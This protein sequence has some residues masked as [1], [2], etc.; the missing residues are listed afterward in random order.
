MLWALW[1]AARG[2]PR[3]DTLVIFIL[4]TLVM[5]SAGCVINDFADR[6]F[7][8]RVERTRLRPLVTGA[9][10]VRAALILF[11]SLLALALG[12]VLLTNRL[13]LWMACA[14]ALLAA[15]YPLAKRYTHLAQVHLGVAFGW[16]VP[17]AYAAEIER[18]PPLVWLVYCAAILWA[19]IYD[20]EYAMVDREDDIKLGLRS[21]AILFGDADRT[22]MAALMTLMLCNLLLIGRQAALAWPYYAALAMAAG[23]FAYQLWLIRARARDGCFKAF[24]NNNWV[25]AVIFAGIAAGLANA[26]GVQPLR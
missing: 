21:T 10:T 3:W 25:G 18:L 13:T 8:G 22:I 12:L 16:A 14:G 15:T 2:L 7:D 23:L 4:G 6:N 24:L 1:L 19:I 9:V 26:G 17:M 20:T 11:V 5:R